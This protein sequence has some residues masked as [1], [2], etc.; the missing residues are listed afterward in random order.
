[1]GYMKHKDIS[2][3]QDISYIDLYLDTDHNLHFI[4]TLEIFLDIEFIII[5]IETI[6]I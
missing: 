6:K 3:D 5:I 1:M 4:H 2:Q